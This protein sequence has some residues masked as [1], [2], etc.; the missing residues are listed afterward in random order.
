MKSKF[1][2]IGILK[3]IFCCQ[4]FW[5]KITS[6]SNRKKQ[7][8]GYSF[9]KG[10]LFPKNR[11]HSPI[12]H[13]QFAIVPSKIFSNP[14]KVS[15][16]ADLP[17]P[18]GINTIFFGLGGRQENS[19]SQTKPVDFLF[20]WTISPAGAKTASSRTTYSFFL[21]PGPINETI[22]NDERKVQKCK[23]I[24]TH[25]VLLKNGKNVKV[26]YKIYCN[27]LNLLYSHYIL[28]DKIVL[29]IIIAY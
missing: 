7:S 9:Q 11:P 2:K 15:P 17:F 12:L 25:T 27:S 4:I 16:I 8:F 22:P 29:R 1:P 14:L 18:W 5:L 26:F 6:D 10:R 23:F 28:L 13:T 24:R 21:I 3:N 19:P 20:E